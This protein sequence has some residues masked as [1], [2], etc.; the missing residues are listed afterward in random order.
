MNAY[1][2]AFVMLCGLVGLLVLAKMAQSRRQSYMESLADVLM[3]TIVVALV[4][5]L[6]YAA[7]AVFLWLGEVKWVKSMDDVQAYTATE[8]ALVAAL[9]KGGRK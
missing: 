9:K 7:V 3:V 1:Q 4:T 5:A 2:V 6:I 8:G